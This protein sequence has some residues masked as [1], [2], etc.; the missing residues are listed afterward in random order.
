MD[1]RSFFPTSKGVNWCENASRH[2]SVSLDL[3]RI[4]IP[5][6]TCVSSS[7]L[8]QTIFSQL[9]GL[10]KGS[11]GL[12]SASLALTFNSQFI[13]KKCFFFTRT[14]LVV[15]RLWENMD[16][17]HPQYSVT[18]KMQSCHQQ[19]QSGNSGNVG[20]TDWV[21]SCWKWAKGKAN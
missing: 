14:Q 3:A 2:Q 1:W 21:E 8:S 7:K 12:F 5:P 18:V 19:C 10:L 15:F 6:P 16:Y 20:T 4:S 11:F 17:L 13:R 9:N